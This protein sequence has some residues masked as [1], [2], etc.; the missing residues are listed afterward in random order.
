MESFLLP[1]L[2]TERKIIANNLAF[3]LQKSPLRRFITLANYVHALKS[4]PQR[5]GSPETL[6]QLSKADTD[7]LQIVNIALQNM[8]DETDLAILRFCSA[9]ELRWTSDITQCPDT[10]VRTVSTNHRQFDYA[11]ALQGYALGERYAFNATN[12]EVQAWIWLLSEAGA[13]NSV[14]H[15]GWCMDHS[16]ILDTRIFV[17]GQQQSSP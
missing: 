5:N 7:A 11:L 14:S 10:N 3:A 15:S 1:V 4:R 17:L 2:A 16:L 13:E 8:S 6:H 12:S 9:R